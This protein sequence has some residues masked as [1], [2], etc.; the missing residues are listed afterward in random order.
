MGITQ[1]IADAP[2][3]PE[4]PLVALLGEWHVSLDTH[5]IM[6]FS[7]N[8]WTEKLPGTTLNVWRWNVIGRPDLGTNTHPSDGMVFDTKEAA[9]RYAYEAGLLG[10]WIR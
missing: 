3:N 1:T 8:F 9:D 10:Q 4:L 6:H 7:P 5:E 2:R